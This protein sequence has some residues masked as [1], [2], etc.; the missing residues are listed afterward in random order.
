MKIL[1]IVIIV[2]IIVCLSSSVGA[3]IF[4]KKKNTETN[5]AVNLYNKNIDD[6]NMNYNMNYQN[7]KI[8]YEKD[9]RKMLGTMATVIDNPKTEEIKVNNKTITIY[10]ANIEYEIVNYLDERTGKINSSAGGKLVISKKQ[11]TIIEKPVKVVSEII[12]TKQIE[13]DDMFTVYYNYD[14]DRT[15][16]PFLSEKYITYLNKI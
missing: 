14:I 2:L 4:L 12:T 7:N 5:N 10:I 16:P 15:A 1:Y 11:D 8:Y 9:L 6:Y 3:F 13:K